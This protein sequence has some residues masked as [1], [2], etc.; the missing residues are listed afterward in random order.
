[1]KINRPGMLALLL[2][3][4]TTTAAPA[5]TDLEHGIR[6]YEDEKI[7][8]AKIFFLEHL[9]TDGNNAVCHFYLGRIHI[10]EAEYQ[11]AIV[12]LEA[13]IESDDDQPSYHYW[14]AQACMGR[15]N[16]V[17]AM[18]KMGLAKKARKACERAVEI[19]P[20]YLDAREW[21][22]GYYLNAPGIAGGSMDKA[23][24]QAEAIKN[25]SP[26]DGHRAFAQIYRR[27]ENYELM[28][29]EIH[30]ALALR[31]ENEEMQ[32]LLGYLYVDTE[33]YERAFAQ[34]EGMIKN[35]P[36]DWTAYYQVGRTGAISGQN[37]DRAEECMKRYLEADAD[38]PSKSA[39]HWRLGMVYEH[40]EDKPSA[41]V[42]YE[43]ALELD[44]DYGPAKES[45]KNL[46]AN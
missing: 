25:I 13:A 45:L 18:K 2:V 28:E 5:Q 31:P 22:A 16:E 6:L 12:S 46:Q 7:A 23:K 3:I 10:D 19:D 40:K 44:P 29:K 37:L 36:E 11:D 38:N 9:E 43:A 32:Y 30:A 15:I 26:F 42:S 20:A 24:Q 21:L 14:Y 33:D 35:D 27:E 1:M 41:L 17:G 8:E 34:F 4:A 39:A